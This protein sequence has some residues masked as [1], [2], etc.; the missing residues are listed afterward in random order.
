RAI[1]EA[2]EQAVE[3]FLS[4]RLEATNGDTTDEDPFGQDSTVNILL[5]GLDSRA[6]STE[7]HCDAIQLFTID[8]DKKQVTIT[9]VPRGTYSPLPPGK[10]TTSTDYYVSNACGLGGIDYG[11]GQI[12]KILGVSADYIVM[13]GFS[14]T[15]GALRHLQLPTTETLQWLRYRRG[16]QIGEPQRAHNHSTFLKQLLVERIGTEDARIPQSLQYVLYRL[17]DTDLSFA[18]TQVLVDTIASFDVAVHPERVVLRMKPEYVVKEIVYDPNTLEQTLEEQIA[19][20]RRWLSDADY[21]GITQETFQQTL[22]QIVADKKNDPE[23]LAWAFDHH[24]WL[25]IDDA[26]VREAVHYDLLTHM[27]DQIPEKEERAGLIADYIL[28]MRYTGQQEW[29]QKGHA[30]LEELH[31]Q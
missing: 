6:G 8:K 24:L 7:A 12:Q 4:A 19:P 27:L 3:S 30:L 23:F 13:V 5:L 9:A 15:L 25:Q 10:G 16:Y 29:E 17:I 28:E 26:A 18:Q 31:A 14:E 2:K 11:V 1:A 21:S 20:I 22:T